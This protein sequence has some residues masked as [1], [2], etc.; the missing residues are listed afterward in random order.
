[1]I[2]VALASAAPGSPVTDFAKLP[3]AEIDTAAV[4]AALAHRK[5]SAVTYEKVRMRIGKILDFAK[6]RARAAGLNV[7]GWWRTG[8]IRR[9]LMATSSMNHRGR[10]SR[11]RE[12]Y[13]A[14]PAADLPAFMQ[15]TSRDRI[16]R[17]QGADVDDFVR[18]RAPPKPSA[19]SALKSTAICG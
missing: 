6:Y 7:D 1:M 8:A 4:L 16:Q 17:E 12:S 3:V 13:K 11:K 10:K 18:P 9:D 5:H 19:A 2:K 15:R 14:M